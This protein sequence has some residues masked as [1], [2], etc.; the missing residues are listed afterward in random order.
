MSY[1]ILDDGRL[2]AGDDFSNLIIYN[3]DTFNPEINIQN[4]LGGLWN[5]YN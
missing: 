3:K 5:F 4:N 2:A 1:K